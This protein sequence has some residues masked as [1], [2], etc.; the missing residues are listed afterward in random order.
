MNTETIKPQ[1][2]CEE[3][4]K[5]TEIAIPSEKHE[6]AL[7]AKIRERF[8]EVQELIEDMQSKLPTKRK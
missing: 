7:L 8:N 3:S 5:M 2:T 6:E 1:L 4:P